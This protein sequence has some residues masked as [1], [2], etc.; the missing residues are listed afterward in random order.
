M[1][2]SDGELDRRL[3]AMPLIEPPADLRSSIMGEVAG[4]RSQVAGHFGAAAQRPATRDLF[5]RRW[6]TAAWAVAAALV[7]AFV[8]MQPRREA[9]DVVGTM[10]PRWPVVERFGNDRATLVV[11]RRGDFY[12]LEAVI[13]GPRPV[14]TSI[15][16]DEQKLAPTGVSLGFD[17]SFG[18]DQVTFTLRNPSQGAGVI[19]RRVSRAATANVRVSIEN[20]EVL[21]AAV[22]LD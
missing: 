21:R 4:R 20:Q 14:T 9:T 19:V 7:L 3:S 22:P 5:S 1:P 6:L 15:S 13:A 12:A 2:L 11:L 10:A 17:A 8:I 18:K 16:W